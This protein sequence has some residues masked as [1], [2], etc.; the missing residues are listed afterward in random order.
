MLNKIRVGVGGGGG[1][2]TL[3]MLDSLFAVSIVVTFF[4]L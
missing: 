3:R 2:G 4:K 1:G